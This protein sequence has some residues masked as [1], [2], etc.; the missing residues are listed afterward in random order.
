MVQ[1][2]LPLGDSDHLVDG[3]IVNLSKFLIDASTEDMHLLW[4]I[5][6]LQFAF[7]SA[8]EDLVHVNMLHFIN[9]F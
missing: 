1:A 3:L 7:P 8:F 6:F 4:R 5:S 2:F 9:I